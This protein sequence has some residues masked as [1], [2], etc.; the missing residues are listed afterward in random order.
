MNNDQLKVI[1]NMTSDIRTTSELIREMSGKTPIEF[2]IGDRKIELPQKLKAALKE[3]CE[4]FLALLNKQ[5]ECISVSGLP[6][7][8]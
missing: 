3:K 5:F 6:Q 1:Q 2:H 8:H 4:D 7:R